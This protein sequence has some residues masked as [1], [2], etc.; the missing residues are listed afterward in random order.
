MPKTILQISNNGFATTEPEITSPLP[1]QHIPGAH[2]TPDTDSLQ[3]HINHDS[4]TSRHTKSIFPHNFFARHR[5]EKP[6]TSPH[7]AP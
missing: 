6:K 7:A 5:T 2:N 3:N 1:P 4:A